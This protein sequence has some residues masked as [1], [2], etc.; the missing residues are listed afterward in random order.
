M[1]KV[2]ICVQPFIK[3]FKLTAEDVGA[4]TYPAGDIVMRSGNDPVQYQMLM[5][6]LNFSNNAMVR[7]SIEFINNYKAEAIV[8]AL[9]ANGIPTTA[10][11]IPKQVLSN[12]YISY[13][14]CN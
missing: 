7:L 3:N 12:F 2:N 11:D 5:D 6:A 10:A 4:Q 9:V 14:V 1:I 8:T 13:P